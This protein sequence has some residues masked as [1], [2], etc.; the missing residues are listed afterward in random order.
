MHRKTYKQITEIAESVLL[1]LGSGWLAL[2]LY[3]TQLLLTQ[4]EKLIGIFTN[5]SMA[6]SC[7]VLTYFLKERS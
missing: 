4:S 3:P 2:S 7:F 5:L 1:N 6:A